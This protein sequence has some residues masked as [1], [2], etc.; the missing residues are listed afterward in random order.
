MTSLTI[1][2][3]TINPDNPEGLCGSCARLGR[4]L[5]KLPCLRGKLTESVL[6]RQIVDP[7]S[8]KP[9]FSIQFEKGIFKPI[10]EWNP[11]NLKTI[12]LTQNFNS[13]LSL[14]VYSFESSTLN[15]EDITESQRFIYQCPWALPHSQLHEFV[16][17]V[18]N[19]LLR[20]I[21]KAVNSK[22][23][24]EDKLALAM[25]TMASELTQ[26]KEGQVV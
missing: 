19:F 7:D 21:W 2:Q 20:S 16:G 13:T 24:R 6:F 8:R 18:D 10:T 11:E 3:C 23:D 15:S 25:F 1:S 17:Q 12:T 9:D 22:V 4:T 5:S 14:K 26:R